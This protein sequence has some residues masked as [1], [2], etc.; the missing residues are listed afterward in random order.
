MQIDLSTQKYFE[1]YLK[2][3]LNSIGYNTTG[4][5]WTKRVFMSWV[6]IFLSFVDQELELFV[7]AR[8]LLILEVHQIQVLSDAA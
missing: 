2:L 5:Y 6:F 8:Q 7:S 1:F 4:E 3:Y